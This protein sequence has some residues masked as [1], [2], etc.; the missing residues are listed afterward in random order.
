M[1]KEE[2]VAKAKTVAEIARQEGKIFR[3][4]SNAVKNAK[5]ARELKRITSGN[6]K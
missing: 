4:G 6:A 1:T 3:C 5:L 2:L